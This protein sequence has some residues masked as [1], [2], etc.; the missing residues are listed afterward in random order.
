MIVWSIEGYDDNEYIYTLWV[1]EGEF[2][3]KDIK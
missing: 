3:K 2:Y 1:Y